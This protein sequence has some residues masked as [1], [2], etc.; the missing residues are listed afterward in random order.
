MSNQ[1]IIFDTTLRDGEQALR[2][3]LSVK[4]KLQ[5]AYALER[6][7][8][9]VMEVGFPVSSPGDFESVQTIA[10]HIKH[11]R[12]CALARAVDKD[13]DVAAE[14]LKVAE[15]FR[16][17][18]FIATSTLHIES[19]LRRSFDDVLAMA[20]HAVTR[21]RRYT[22]DVEF[23]CEDAGRTPIDNL[24]R[25]VEAAIKAGARTINIPD[26]V[27][28]TIPSQFGGIIDTLFNRVPNIDQ[29][30]ISVHCHNDLGLSVANSIAAVQAGARQI[31][32]TVNGIGERAGNC[33]LEEIA[34]IIRTRADL[35]NVHTN[36][37]HQDIYRTSQLVSQLC[38]MPIQPNKAIVGANAFAHSSGIHQDGVLKNKSTYEII[39]PESIGLNQNQLNLTSRSGRAAV[40]HRM[41]AMGYSEG[42]YDLDSLYTAFLKLADKKGQVFD[43]DLEAL[44]FINM[45][46]EDP[47]HFRLD[48]LSVQS[49]GSVMATASVRLR[50][51]EE[52][53][54]EAA[55][56]N[57]PVDAVYQCITRL[58]GY[59]IQIVNY[60]LSAK[61]QGKDALGQVDIVADYQGRRFHG[62]G[63]ATDII[64]SSAQALV[65]VLNAIHRAGRVSEEKQ[66]IQ[67]RNIEASQP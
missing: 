62:V 28:Y 66:R 61:G 22:D 4:E 57:G 53:V 37:H 42:S 14:A 19:K 20:V 30:V 52:T 44:A 24:C 33:S 17:H 55:T 3:S 7:G 41:D 11:S 47:E 18:T 6:L 23:S 13:I 25:V 32:C 15:A 50:C 59:E 27:G 54:S 31:E 48:Y 63:L 29:A 45:Q 67:Q 21:A 26:T 36:I 40:K 16:I 8:V 12:V 10:R 39:T 49:G 43:Y 60:Q 64:E 35:L 38:N 56:G 34:M 9:D 65:H 2:A 58:T 46:Q 51:G 1:V 5:I